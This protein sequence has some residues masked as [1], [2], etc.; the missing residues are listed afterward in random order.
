MT[1]HPAVV[2]H[3]GLCVRDLDRSS[4]FYC[5]LLGFSEAGRLD[6]A[7]ATTGPLLRIE[8]PVNLRAV[9]LVRDGFVLELLAFDRPGNAPRRERDF[10]EPGLTHLSVSVADVDGVCARVHDLGGEVLT[11]THI[12]MAVTIRDPDGQVIELLPMSYRER[13]PR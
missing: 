7:D 2:N 9:Y 4:R 3:V 10:T 1:T 6:A 5:E 8:P 12:G 11:D 13:A